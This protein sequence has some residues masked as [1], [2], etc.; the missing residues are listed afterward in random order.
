[1]LDRV[2]NSRKIDQLAI[3]CMSLTGINATR[4]TF[5]SN[6]K[7]LMPGETIVYDCTNKRIKSSERIYIT[8]RSNSSFNPAGV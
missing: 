8:P 7:Q 2:P 4:N 3:S 5:F 6:I 1:M